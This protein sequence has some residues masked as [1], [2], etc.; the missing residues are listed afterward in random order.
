[1]L[2]GFSSTEFSPGAPVGRTEYE[3][4]PSPTPRFALAVAKDWQL[5][6]VWLEGWAG[7]PWSLRANTER[8]VASGRPCGQELSGWGGRALFPATGGLFSR[9]FSQQQRTPLPWPFA[10]SHF[11]ERICSVSRMNTV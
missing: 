4:C 2:H 7:R 8:R 6:E 3:L 11:T 5:L 10:T 9:V 1:M